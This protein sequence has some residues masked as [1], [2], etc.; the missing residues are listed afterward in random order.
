[1]LSAAAWAAA[2]AQIVHPA[3]GRIAFDPYWYQR[4]FLASYHEPRRII[5]K[6]RQIGFSQ[7]FALEALYAAITE[8]EQMI[9]LVSRSQ[10]L[11]VNLLRYCYLTY[12]NLH[13]APALIK[14]NESELGTANGFFSGATYGLGG[15]ETPGRGADDEMSLRGSGLCMGL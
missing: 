1:V 11:A 6:A 13:T 2:N 14:A 9:L 12:N 4:D 7:V 8:P 15:V 5:L 10:D 3:R